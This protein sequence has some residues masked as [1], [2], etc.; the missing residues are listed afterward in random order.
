MPDL[1]GK[2][3]IVTGGSKGIGRATTVALVKE[4]ATVV[5]TY[6]TNHEASTNLVEELGQDNSLS[7]RFD[8]GS[9]DDIDELI[10]TVMENFGRIDIIVANAGCSPA[11]ELL[12][13]TEADFDAAFSMNVKGSFFLVQKAAPYLSPGSHI[14]LLSSSL[15]TT[16]QVPADKLLY[17]STKGA[18]EQMARLMAKDLGRRSIAVNA[19]APG[20]TATEAFFKGKP[21][22]V[23]KAI[24]RFSP[25]GRIGTPE[26]TADAILFLCSEQS[27]WVAWQTLRV[28]GGSA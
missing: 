7:L 28:N 26:E 14:V 16:S 8:A 1:V 25:Y 24:E 17:C 12:Q 2:I 6:N 27:A 13:T 11:I 21:E 3:A 10:K 4:G 22:P 19:I 20:P 23:I 5:F 18:I 9:L 15:C